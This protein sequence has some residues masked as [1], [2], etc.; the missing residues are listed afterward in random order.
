M[1]PGREGVVFLLFSGDN[2]QKTRHC[3]PGL[4]PGEAIPV[5]AII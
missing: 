4:D 1:V 5:M 2:I 3:D